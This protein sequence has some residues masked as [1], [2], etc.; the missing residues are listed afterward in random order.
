MAGIFDDLPGA[1]TEAVPGPDG[2]SGCGL[3]K[4]IG[5]DLGRTL[6]Q[7]CY[8]I[9]A[10]EMDKEEKPAVDAAELGP[11]GK[12]WYRMGFFRRDYYPD[13]EKQFIEIHSSL[14]LA[15]GDFE[16]IIYHMWVSSLG[17]QEQNK[18]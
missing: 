15:V 12:R 14:P 9:L 2:Y 13:H 11:N 1:R 17:R 4:P 3:E 8:D 6:Y 10:H 5:P 16:S 7:Q 18:G